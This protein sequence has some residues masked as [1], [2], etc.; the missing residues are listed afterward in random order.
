MEG[1]TGTQAK[2]TLDA[3]TKEALGRTTPEPAP[4][5]KKGLFDLDA[6]KAPPTRT[7]EPTPAPVIASAPAS[8]K[9]SLFDLDAPTAR[10][11]AARL[12][13]AQPAPPAAPAQVAV[14][15]PAPV[16]A[17][18]RLSA[19]DTL[20]AAPAE[21][22]VP[23]AAAPVPKPAPVPAA[24]PAAAPIARSEPEVPR[25]SAVD[26]LFAF[27][28]TTDSLPKMASAPEPVG[29]PASNMD[30][31]L[32]ERSS[33]DELAEKNAYPGKATTME[34]LASSLDFGPEGI[35]PQIELPGAGDDAKPHHE[36]SFELPLTAAKAGDSPEERKARLIGRLKTVRSAYKV[37][38]FLD[39]LDEERKECLAAFAEYETRLK[40]LSQVTS[41]AARKD[42][43]A[44]H[45]ALPLEGVDELDRAMTRIEDRLLA[46]DE[47]V[48]QDKFRAR[49]TKEKHAPKLLLRYARFLACRRFNVGFRR[50]RFEHLVNELLTVATSDGRWRL[51]P[52]D[53]ARPVLL[54]I[55]NGLPPSGQDNDREAAVAY[56]RESLDRLAGIAT[57]EEFFE[58]GFF[59]DVHGYKISMREQ[60][61]SPEFL[62]LSIAINVEIHNRIEGWI[63][64]LERLHKTNQLTQEGPPRDFLVGQLRSQEEAVQGVFGSFRHP[65][66]RSS[67]AIPARALAQEPGNKKGETKKVETK[68]ARKKEEKENLSGQEQLE[69]LASQQAAKFAVLTVV[70]CLTFGYVLIGS[71]TVE[72]NLG[73]GPAISHEQVMAMSPLLEFAIVTND[74]YLRGRVIENKWNSMDANQKRIAADA[75]VRHM[76]EL[77]LQNAELMSYKTPAINV[78]LGVLTFVDKSGPQQ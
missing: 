52:R 21:P 65:K 19:V 38:G 6:P 29:A 30:D 77:G 41:E 37:L 55:L 7:L 39:I 67:Q 63:A 15:A 4:D 54:Q 33:L 31:M 42:V 20:F 61:T 2:I 40:A 14:P 16:P 60:A 22:H 9:A 8:E 5:K 34:I 49:I 43:V 66:E 32:D 26:A 78:E 69:K 25:P 53:K 12:P 58:S 1:T 72:V 50:D 17:A 64:G 47:Y 45:K 46:I 23:V 13:P 62:Y 76:T 27:E 56:L 59:L 11:V 71:G 73:G 3:Q 74:G 10:S 51:L 36:D 75:L 57:H 70:I 68:R 44:L 48:P 18:E 35:P 28:A 24:M